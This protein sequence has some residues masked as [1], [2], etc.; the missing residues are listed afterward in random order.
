MD[1]SPLSE[2]ELKKSILLESKK[3]EKFFKWIENHMPKN[4]FKE[5]NQNDLTLI[6][7]NLMNLNLQGYFSQVNIK[8]YAIILCIDSPKAD[9]NILKNFSEHGI[10]YYK[11]FVSNKPPPFD[12][13]ENNLRIAIIHFSEG[14][15]LKEEVLT[16]ERKEELS[17]L[18]IER[19]PKV[20]QEEFEKLLEGMNRRF[21]LSMT[22][23]RLITAFDMFFRA[24]SRDHCQYEIK[25]NEDWEKTGSPSLQIVFAWRNTPKHNFLYRV[26]QTVHRYH[27]D[28]T[29][30]AA[31]YIEPYSP[32]S[33]VIM[34]LGIH[35]KEGKA[36]W[37]EADIDKFMREL[38][39]LK[40]F[41]H[42]DLIEKTFVETNRAS[43]NIGNLLRAMVS[44]I[45]Q[46]L[47][48]EDPN[49]YTLSNIEEGLCRH[50]ELT[51]KLSKAFCKK[52]EP[53]K[54]NLEKYEKLK[55]E[56]LE[57]VD[58]LDTGHA[59][60]DE[61]RK[62]ILYQGINFVDH[63]L[64]TNFYRSN[65]SSLGFR[66]D[67]TYLDYAPFERAE[68][69][70]ELPYGIFFFKGMN[71]IGFHIRFKDL[72]RG[73]L[74][75]VAPQ[76]IEEL[77][78]ERDNV[79]TECYNLAY[80]QQKKNKDIPE[81][82]SKGVILLDP[83]ERVSG[84]MKIYRKELMNAKV[85]KELI[86]TKVKNLKQAQK[87]AFMHHSQRSY[88]HSMLTLVNCEEAGQLRAKNVVDYLNRPEY[89]YL[90]PDENMQNTVIEWIADY[91]VKH[92]YKPG[93]SVMS[94]KP[95]AGIN[96]KKYGVTSLGVNV[97]MHETLNYLG[98]DPQKEPF[99]LKISGG[100]D[101]D[102]AGNQI[103]NLKR[104][105][106]DTAKLLAITDISGTIYDPEGLDLEELATLFHEAKSIRF[107]PLDK[108]HDHGFLLDLHT[109]REQKA[110]AQQTLCTHKEKGKLSQSWLSGNE[111]NH[112][113][114]HNLFQIQTDI[115]IPAGGR[116][117]T[118]NIKNYTD[119]LNEKREPTA[120]AI[121]EGAN[122]YL[123]QEA[124]SE[125]EKLNT[126]IIKDSSCNKGGVIT[127]S[128]EVLSSL[129]LNEE[130]FLQEKD[131]LVEEI[132]NKVKQAA[133][134]EAKLLLSEH[135]QTG[136]PLTEISEEISE[137]INLYKYELL[138]HFESIDLSSD[139]S[140]PLIQCLLAYCPEHLSKN[141][142]NQ[143]IE[144][145]PDLHKKA[146]IACY[147]SSHLVY[148]KG[149]KWAPN[150]IDVLP[151]ISK[152]PSFKKS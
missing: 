67:P 87:T 84:D 74:R 113:Y 111:M 11:T 43:G 144:N 94:S 93:S 42:D 8:N 126:L 5:L 7:H 70:P 152:D 75:T 34:S 107:Y 64:K 15:N 76:K 31:T 4:F 21:L 12:N 116:P 49:L 139:P 39:N 51:I 109:K 77:N 6:T 10:R 45:H 37:E 122:L 128:F 20:T 145:I 19:N 147:I 150:I 41:E 36:A 46:V 104:F 90:G 47:V 2:E 130:Q 30:F 3:F 102:V 13:V 9:L 35:G 114:R 79:F 96:H 124:R 83:F 58:D 106:P 92:S 143:I 25:K 50:P 1:N 29:R 89:I 23:S 88:F 98:I 99:T 40:Y 59:K 132:L 138:D 28:M 18:I 103:L 33:I 68:K 125:L 121:V 61:R 53:G 69:F 134:N 72:S 149:L 14:A 131:I 120:R 62:N 24:K 118:L 101:G 48:Q 26:V 52:F 142:S 57:A 110:Y 136:K 146:V 151:L 56:Y 65:K 112:L 44:F 115:F 117:R 129:I 148:N 78:I 32:K 141:Y 81:G 137:K 95:R 108:L 60:N 133:E 91:S 16:E 123:T 140:D 17:E 22:T 80:T 127:S 66:L 135:E 97:Y 71:F 82:G 119:F 105:Y 100:P 27:L 73:G 86:E 38:V 63:T 85:D 54:N 55:E